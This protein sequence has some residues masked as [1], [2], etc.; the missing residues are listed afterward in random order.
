MERGEKTMG[1]REGQRP[2][3][4]TGASAAEPKSVPW[5]PLPPQQGQQQ[6]MAEVQGKRGP[7]GPRHKAAGA[8]SEH[9]NGAHPRR[10]QL[11]G[12]REGGEQGHEPWLLHRP[13]SAADMNRDAGL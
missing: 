5:P 3:A 6:A 8:A 7:A 9:R 4:P 10:L 11:A 1:N 12:H 2:R 13:T